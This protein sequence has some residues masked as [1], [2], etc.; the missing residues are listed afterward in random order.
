MSQIQSNKPIKVASIN[1][2]SKSFT[3]KNSTHI[4]AVNKVSF[5]L[6]QGEVLSLLGPNGAGKTTL[7]NMML[8]R[9]SL[10]SGQMELLGFKPG[11]IELK[12]LCGAMLQISGLPDMSTVKEH[13][14]LF[15]CYY[16]NPMKY[17]KVIDLAGLHDIQNKYSKNL[18]GGQKQ[19]LLFALSICGNPKLLFL[20]EPSVGMDISS[21]KTLW[22][23]INQLKDN[24]T[25]IILTTHYLEEADQLSDR[26]IMLNQG[27]IIQ[28]GTPDQIKANINSKKIRFIS[29]VSKEVFQKQNP[30]IP[31]ENIGKY[32]EV[33]SNDS[34]T[35]LKQLFNLTNDITDLS[36]TGAALED[37]F[38]LINKE[39]DSKNQTP[40]ANEALS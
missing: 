15:Q 29:T 23:T 40:N 12:R 32:Y 37:A 10:S 11:N 2:V 19:R 7:I 8:G 4:K 13:I 28:E 1:Q 26:I 9:L 27:K 20:D 39:N 16:P 30:I 34:V 3:I 33:Q 38:L 18:S 5:D 14:E 25:S 35:T 36:V 6:H 21:R 17:S 22:K 31:V 24:G